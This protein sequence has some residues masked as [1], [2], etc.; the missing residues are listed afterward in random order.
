MKA[1]GRVRGQRASHWDRL[2]IR[3]FAGLRVLRLCVEP[4]SYSENPAKILPFPCQNS[5]VH[6]ENL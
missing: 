2:V 1:E 6:N 5:G 3:V 4:V